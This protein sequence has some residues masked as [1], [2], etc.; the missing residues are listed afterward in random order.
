[1]SL[2]LRTLKKELTTMIVF[3]NL[4]RG[5]VQYEFEEPFG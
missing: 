2:P 4:N 3:V 5:N 1:M